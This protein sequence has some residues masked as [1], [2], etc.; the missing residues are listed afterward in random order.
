MLSGGKLMVA[1]TGGSAADAQHLVAEFVSRLTLNRPAMR[2]IALTTDT[3]ILTAIGNDYDYNNIFER[4]IEAIGQTGD[5]FPGI[6][7]SGNSKNVVKGLHKA[8][9][10]G[11][12]TT[13]FSGNGGGV[14]AELC[15]INVIV[16][17]K[18][19]MHIQEVQLALEHTFCM[20]VERCYFPDFEA[21]FSAN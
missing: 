11:I 1:E 18:I 16:P 8:K 10:M 13:G 20:I 2:A 4:R 17:S 12:A 15:D 9:E 5:V 21:T 3:S 7:T 14:M 19:T 6:S